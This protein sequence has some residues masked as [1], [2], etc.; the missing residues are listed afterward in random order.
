M[1]MNMAMPAMA[2]VSAAAT[3]ATMAT[4]TNTTMTTATTSDYDWGARHDSHGFRPMSEWSE[5]VSNV[6]PFQMLPF[7]PSSQ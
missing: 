1:A 5:D 3:I 4:A 7:E 2:T 6:A